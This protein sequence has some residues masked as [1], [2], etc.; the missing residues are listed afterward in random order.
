MHN[1]ANSGG[2]RVAAATV[3]LAATWWLPGTQPANAQAHI[4]LSLSPTSVAAGAADLSGFTDFRSEALSSREPL[5]DT[6]IID[7]DQ[8]PRIDH[9]DPIEV[10]EDRTDTTG[11][12]ATDPDSPGS[13]L[14][15]SIPGGAG[16]A[17][18]MHFVLDAQ[19]DLAFAEPKDYELPDGAVGDRI[20]EVMVSLSDG[21]T[22]LTA[23]LTVVLADVDEPPVV[24]GSRLVRFA[25]NNTVAVSSYSAQDPEGAEVQWG[26]SGTDAAVFVIDGGVLSFVSPPD[27]E[28]PADRGG[29]SVYDVVVEAF[30]GALVASFSVVVLVTDVDEAPTVSGRSE[31][32]VDEHTS[33]TLARYSAV[34]PE[35]RLV[36]WQLSGDDAAAFTIAD[37]AL[38]FKFPADFEDEQDADSDNVYEV[39]VEAFDGLNTGALDL[40]VQVENVDEPG[41]LSLW[42]LQP[43]V[44]QALSALLNDPD[45]IEAASVVWGWERSS[46]RVSWTTIGTAEA[47]AYTPVAQDVG[48]YLRVTATYAD[49]EDA[50]KRVTRASAGAVDMALSTNRSP[51]F[52]RDAPT[53]SIAENAPFGTLVGIPVQATDP[54]GDVLS[55]SRGRRVFHGAAFTIDRQTGQ[56]RTAY[57]FEYESF[58]N[59]LVVLVVVIDPSGADDTTYVTIAVEDVDEPPMVDAPG[60]AYIEEGSTVAVCVCTAVDPDGDATPTWRLSG[61]DAPA[62][63]LDAGTLRFV[64]PPDYEAPADRGRDNVYEVS[65]VANDSGGDGTADIIVNVVD[66][67]EAPIL[68]GPSELSATAPTTATVASFVAADPEDDPVRWSLAGDDAQRFWIDDGRLRFRAPPS[69]D[70]PADADADNV[71]DIVVVATD[72]ELAAEFAVEVTVTARPAPSGVGPIGSGGGGGSRAPSA[73][74]LRRIA[75]QD[76]FGTARAVMARWADVTTGRPDTAVL[77]SGDAWPDALAAAGLAGT[78]GGPVLLA[79]PDGLDEAQATAAAVAGITRVVVVGGEAVVPSTVLDDLDGFEVSRVAGTDRYRTAAAVARHTGTAGAFRSHGAT[80]IV[81]SGEAFADAIVAGPLAVAGKHPVLLTQAERLPDA[82]REALAALAVRHVVIVGGPAAVSDAVEQAIEALGIAVTRVAGA[83]RYG[84]AVRFAQFAFADAEHFG[85]ASG[86]VP[87]DALSAAAYLG[88]L[89][90]PVLLT[91][92]DA[93]PEVV[94]RHLRVAEA[95]TLEI[96]IFGGAAAVSS[97]VISELRDALQ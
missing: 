12:A 50:G 28:M 51:E 1:S 86:A 76:R 5:S 43:R 31:L 56:L 90:A 53:F 27:R 15:W 40:R 45:I 25:E 91:E 48:T 70:Q 78:L 8:P 54:D 7:A 49:G 92:T 37:G 11:L 26:L 72:G 81:V 4:V 66:V 35:R 65:V 39:T 71:Y 14:T 73:L 23:D 46:D 24:T 94:R 67:N 97:A 79:G 80:A 19:D 6:H 88:L 96:D 29:D 22:S 41:L 30:D 38:A 68:S 61:P 64:T 2:L 42:P 62:F 58:L 87:F 3:V 63:E 13:A 9:D 59:T 18:A 17:D 85:L 82:A 36:A 20:Y 77:V 34:D 95:E 74:Q 32:T 47:D 55:Y 83:D 10:P 16:G 60:V 93:L 84:T 21:L 33:G 89:R 75:G 44:G 69:T 57:A 52:P